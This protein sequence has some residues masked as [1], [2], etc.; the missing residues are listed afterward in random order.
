MTAFKN[1][2]TNKWKSQVHWEAFW[3]ERELLTEFCRV[4]TYFIDA[5][6]CVHT[7]QHRWRPSI[8]HDAVWG[9]PLSNSLTFI[10]PSFPMFCCIWN[11]ITFILSWEAL[12]ILTKNAFRTDLLV[13]NRSSAR[14]EINTP[15]IS[16]KWASSL[17]L[18]NCQKSKHFLTYSLIIFS[19]ALAI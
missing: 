17:N 9:D 14:L 16:D 18:R 8:D 15:F 1:K 11:Y 5:L 10:L 6:V 12:S 2:W 3:H 4:P 19:S 7:H 13:S